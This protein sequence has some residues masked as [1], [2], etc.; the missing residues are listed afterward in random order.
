MPWDDFKH[1]PPVYQILQARRRAGLTADSLTLAEY[2]DPEATSL[3]RM[4]EVVRWYSL[5]AN[6]DHPKLRPMHLGLRCEV[7]NA[8]AATA[9][10]L[11]LPRQPRRFRLLVNFRVSKRALKQQYV[12]R[13]CD[14]FHKAAYSCARPLALCVCFAMR[15]AH[16]SNPWRRP[17]QPSCLV[18]LA[19]L[20]AISGTRTEG[21]APAHSSWPRRGNGG[22]SL[23]SFPSAWSRSCFPPTRC[24]QGF[25]RSVMPPFWGTAS[26]CHRF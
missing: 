19:C 8:T 23:P 12:E 16:A 1:G 20:P 6:I 25:S 17:T 11:R 26:L 21:S 14:Q 15:F 7:L 13:T 5:N 22:H 24:K 2:R 9:I 10:D 4:P 18:D 3:L